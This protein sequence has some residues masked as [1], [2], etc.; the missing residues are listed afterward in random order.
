MA[1]DPVLIDG[2][3]AERGGEL[4][5]LKVGIPNLEVMPD[6]TVLGRP[7]GLGTGAPSA[8]PIGDLGSGGA[9]V[10]ARYFTAAIHTGLSSEM[11]PT[12]TTTVGWTTTNPGV[13]GAEVPTFT[14]AL[15]GVVPASGGGTTNFL[16]ADGTWSPPGAGGV[17]SGAFAP[18]DANYLTLHTGHAALS[19][20]RIFSVGSGTLGSGPS[21][22][23]NL[24][25]TDGGVGTLYKLESYPTRRFVDIVD[26]FVGGNTTTGNI[27]ENGWLFGTN[28]GG[29]NGIGKVANSPTGHPGSIILNSGTTLN[30]QTHIVFGTSATGGAFCTRQVE[31]FEYTV[32][33]PTVTTAYF[34]QAGLGNAG[35][36]FMGPNSVFFEYVPTS[37]RWMFN[38]RENSVNNIATGPQASGGAWCVLNARRIPSGPARWEFSVNDV[39][40]QTVTANPGAV[41]PASLMLRTRNTTTKST[42]IDR[43]RISTAE[44]GQRHHRT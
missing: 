1:I 16:R 40:S 25:V 34:L 26:E 18:A 31:E 35:A 12:N 42:E 15:P 8:I 19:N 14:S 22:S 37:T 29:G 39:V 28:G 27:G 9:P 24:R 33:V 6:G 17:A 4:V 43:F 7:V 30:A 3:I 32:R 44:L 2:V 10:D 13:F 21:Y 5:M 20:E 36:T 11:V 38:A 41:L 23:R